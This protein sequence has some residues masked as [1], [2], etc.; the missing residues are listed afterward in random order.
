M[1]YSKA[2]DFVKAN[3]GKLALLGSSIGMTVV[4]FGAHLAHAT[5][6]EDITNIATSV[7]TSFQ[8]NAVTLLTTVLPFVVTVAIIFLAAKLALRWMKKSAR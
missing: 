2:K 7:G 3:A 5:T 4:S 1:S 6:A 8:T